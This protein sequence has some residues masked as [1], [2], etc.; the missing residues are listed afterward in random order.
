VSDRFEYL[1]ER[2]REWLRA[3]RRRSDRRRARLLAAAVL[4][5]VLALTLLASGGSRERRSPAAPVPAG[6]TAEQ[7]AL[8]D[9]E[10]AL[11]AWGRFAA[12]NDLRHLRGHFWRNGPQY[13]DLLRL[14][15]LR[16]GRRPPGPPAYRFVL[17]HAL[18]LAPS[19]NQRILQGRVQVSRP[20]ER[21][22]SYRWNIWMRRDASAGGR[23]RLWT[24]ETTA[25]PP[26]RSK[27]DPV[28]A[29]AGD[30][31]PPGHGSGH[32][33]TSDR[34]LAIDPTVVL[35]LGDNQY[36]SGTLSHFRRYY[37]STWGRFKTRTRPS[38]GNHDYETAGAAGYFAYFGK[39]ARPAGR[40]YYSFDL[41][42]WHLISLDSNIDLQAGSR[43]DRW[44][45]AD[46]AATAKR[47][48]LAYWHHPR[49]TSGAHQGDNRW[50]G[51]FWNALYTARADVV[52]SSH[53]HNYER[54]ARQDPAGRATPR[55]I[56]QFVV[57]TGGA[58]L[59][60]F[61][62]PKPNSQVRSSSTWGVLVLTLR[63]R[64]Y[65]WRFVSEDGQVVDRGGPV[66]CH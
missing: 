33:A 28:V 29:A 4:A 2:E 11:A 61:A 25:R 42:G 64:S 37:G 57:G 13:Q 24:V 15:K 49:F 43:Q 55:G 8:E 23:W 48:I 51:P 60:G 6:P 31:A 16:A 40:S 30:I 38:P 7:R 46:L 12:T 39:L 41:G 56:R 22:Q 53:E 58:Y 34:V 14:A 36:P 10:R 19:L 3:V 35:P 17:T 45:R 54:F 50:V 1:D 21:R 65:T 62:A 27:R 9:G 5:V 44:L 20:G 32:R 59:I 52:L 47:C 18:V 26:A 66:P 63:P